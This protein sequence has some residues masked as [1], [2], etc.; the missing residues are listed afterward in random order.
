MVDGG[1]QGHASAADKA[2]DEGA[3]EAER[4]RNADGEPVA[5]VVD[6]CGHLSWDVDARHA[7][8]ILAL[9]SL[10]EKI[11]LLFK[12]PKYGADISK[13]I[14]T[15]RGADVAV[16]KAGE[17]ELQAVALLHPVLCLLRRTRLASNAILTDAILQGG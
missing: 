17:G 7:R 5:L 15:H 10:L 12:L 1:A 3:A 4:E 9:A 11:G 16:A 8:P 6:V 2:A 13:Q 14:V